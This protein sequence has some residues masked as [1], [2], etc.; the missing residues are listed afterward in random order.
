VLYVPHW[1]NSF[2]ESGT[3]NFDSE[4]RRKQ[5]SSSCVEEPSI[6][7]DVEVSRLGLMGPYGLR[8]ALWSCCGRGSRGPTVRSTSGYMSRHGVLAWQ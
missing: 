1:Y 5:V 2:S 3:D 4:M 6:W 7:S 8:S